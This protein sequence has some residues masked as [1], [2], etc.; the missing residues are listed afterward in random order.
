VTAK[1]K[2]R[3]LCGLA[4]AGVAT[5]V[6]VRGTAFGAPPAAGDGVAVTPFKINVPDADV[7]DLHERL[8]R[9][10]F[11]DEIPGV[12]WDYGTNAAYLKSI[13][14][15]WRDKYDWRAQEKRLNQF[16]Q[17]KTNIDGLDI[18]FIHQKSPVANATPLLLLNGWPSS[19]VEYAKVI[20]P[21]T[22]PVK[23]GGRATDAFNV[24]IPSMPG[25]G[26]SDKPKERVYDP[27]RMASLWVKLMAR[28]GYDRY[29][30]QGSDWGVAVA[31][32]LALQDP[33]HMFALHLNGCPGAPVPPPAN[34]PR[35]ATPPPVSSNLGYQEIQTT[36][37]QALGQGLAD[38]PVGQAAWILDKWYVWTDQDGDL[39]KVYSKDDILT[40]ISIYWFTNSATS[41]SRL[42]Y[43]SRHADG[44][45]LPSFFEGFMPPLSQ[46]VTVPTGCGNFPSQYDRRGTPP[47]MDPAI[48]RRS[49]EGRYNVIYYTIQP[50]G[51]HFAALEQPE[52]WVKDVRD[53]MAARGQQKP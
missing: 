19:I 43:E 27:A 2:R 12:G 52:A 49:A 4:I 53:F 18:H 30:T 6:S 11:A 10:R 47:N 15:Y 14:A 34:A 44:R 33:N 37:P 41:S 3:I 17:F 28:L 5:L 13:I 23:Y 22:D 42:Y 24:V 39:E 1:A 40:N 29:A 25:Y 38:S 45:L 9:A 46:K 7:R 36:R 50:K 16:A 32:H 21:L 31:T 20:G 51:G 26:F 48:G 8:G 35:P